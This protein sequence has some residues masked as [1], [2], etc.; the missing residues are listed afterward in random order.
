[1]RAMFEAIS[2]RTRVVFIA[3]PNNP[4][5]TCVSREELAWFVQQAP[6]HV[7]VVMDEAYIEFLSNAPDFI[8]QL[9]S[10][11]KH[12]L[13][14]MRTFSKIYGLAGLRVGYGIGTKELIG[15][16]EKVRQ[17]FNLNSLA[18]AAADAALDDTEHVQKTA[19]NNS[20]GLEFFGRNFTALNLEFIPS[21]ANFIL[22]RVG[23]GQRVFEQL[24]KN[25]VIVRP[26]GGYDLPEW[27]RISIGTPQQNQRCLAELKNALS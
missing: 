26:M 6:E 24:Q 12:N 21:A 3:N 8:P 15:V 27:V 1:L 16:L 18:Q 20:M 23:N 14:L 5:G 2:P 7:L 13:L 22:V 11:Q 17:P 25:G 4:T 19:L 9:R 10:G